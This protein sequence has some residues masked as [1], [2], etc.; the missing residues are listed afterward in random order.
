MHQRKEGAKCRE[1]EVDNEGT[2]VV[3]ALCEFLYQSGVG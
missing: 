1:P 3:M 2:D